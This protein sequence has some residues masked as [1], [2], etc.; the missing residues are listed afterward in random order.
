MAPEGLQQLLTQADGRLI[1][2]YDGGC[3]LCRRE[4]RHYR[5]M[6][7]QGGIFWQDI[8]HQPQ[9]LNDTGIGFRDAMALFHVVEPSG[10]IVVGAHGF[11]RIWQRLPGYRWLG[12]VCRY[13]GLVWPM[14]GAYRLFAA[15]RW[16]R[17]S[18]C[19]TCA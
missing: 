1:V 14:D 13:T 8:A 18:A 12:A 7:R 9:V 3:P 4:I 17:R 19:A 11:V 6:D 16:K 10:R 15:W 5:R 2:F